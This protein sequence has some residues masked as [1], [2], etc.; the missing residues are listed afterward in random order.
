VLK[1]A[2]SALLTLAYPVLILVLLRRFSGSLPAPAG[3]ALK[4][5]PVI[6]SAVLFA[7]FFRSLYAPQ[8]LVEKMAR[9]RDPELGPEGVAYTRKVTKL[10]CGFML[11]NGS[12]ALFLAVFASTEAW[13]LYTG[14]IAYVLMGLLFAGEW[15][16]RQ[17]VRHAQS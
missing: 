13:A 7:A 5:Y 11:L 3:F 15:L 2:L 4:L 6:V 12:A 14:V 9:I 16:V 1:R 17:K 8:T 10:W